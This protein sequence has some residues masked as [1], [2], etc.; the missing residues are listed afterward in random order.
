MPIGRTVFAQ[1]IHPG[2]CFPIIPARGPNQASWEPDGAGPRGAPR[3]LRGQARHI[4]SGPRYAQAHRSRH[5]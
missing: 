3:S 1:L 4:L 5:L 2:R